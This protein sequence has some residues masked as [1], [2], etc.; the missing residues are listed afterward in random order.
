M[1][2]SDVQLV[3][4]LTLLLGAAPLALAQTEGETTAPAKPAAAEAAPAAPA[5]QPQAAA[6]AQP[7]LPLKAGL[8]YFGVNATTFSHRSLGTGDTNKQAETTSLGFVMGTYITDMF[9]VE[10]R[11]GFGVT[12]DDPD[13]DLSVAMKYYASWYIGVIYPWLDFSSVYAQYGFSHVRGDATVR[14]NNRNFRNIPEDFMTSSFSVSW[15]AG[16]DLRVAEQTYAVFEFGRLHND[17]TT[18]SKTFQFN[19]GLRYEF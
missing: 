18:D 17:T 3:T 7:E 10:G 11:A 12:G 14:N 5:T 1:V 8:D 2:R 4:V 13:P 9:K 19:L 15:L 16:T 6:P